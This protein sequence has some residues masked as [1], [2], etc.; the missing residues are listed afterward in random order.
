VPT[1]RAKEYQQI[2]RQKLSHESHEIAESDQA[3]LG[4]D[5]SDQQIT[6][7]RAITWFSVAATFAGAE[8]QSL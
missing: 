8:A 2:Q 1:L 5:D 7:S 4:T 3:A 6:R